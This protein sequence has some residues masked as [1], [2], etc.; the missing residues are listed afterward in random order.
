MFTMTT[1]SRDGSAQFSLG[2]GFCDGRRCREKRHRAAEETPGH[3]ESE[4]TE[5]AMVGRSDD[6]RRLAVTH[7]LEDSSKLALVM[8]SVVTTI[9]VRIYRLNLKGSRS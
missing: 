8:A 1:V 6:C 9:R 2:S 5:K 4:T 3:H 7:P